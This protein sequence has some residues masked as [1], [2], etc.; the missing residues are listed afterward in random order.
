[1]K[2]ILLAS[3]KSLLVIV[4]VTC[5]L[6][7]P[8]RAEILD[9]EANHPLLRVI[10]ADLDRSGIDVVQ[11][12]RSDV[13]A[14]TRPVVAPLAN[15]QT[16]LALREERWVR[17]FNKGVMGAIAAVKTDANLK[18]SAFAEKWSSTPK[19]QRVF[20]SFAREDVAHARTIKAALE[21]Q[22]YVAFIYINQAGG[23]PSQPAASVGEYL[24]T[25]G[26]HLVIDTYTAR[27][28]PGVLAETLAFARYRR[29][30]PSDPR[31]NAAGNSPR[32]GNL[33]G[34]GGE[35]VAPRRHIVE[36]YGAK[37]RCPRTRQAIQ[38]F[39][40]A[41]A[42]VRY[43]DVDISP[44]ASRVVGRNTR[45]LENGDLL[46]FIRVDGKPILATSTGLGV[47]LKACQ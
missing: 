33:G 29:P 6:L 27:R 45:W 3:L 39:K 22:G 46:P 15:Y 16:S 10:A 24:R 30:P 42:E 32:P 13:P 20:I 5:P 2:K 1:V 18:R 43:Y 31:P 21:A 34:G 35:V 8:G 28:K 38:L 47:A 40:D 23:S 26:T 7:Q 19:S 25:A 41:G 11:N 4:M 37:K 9:P 17:D 36:I 12:W 14:Y 44:R